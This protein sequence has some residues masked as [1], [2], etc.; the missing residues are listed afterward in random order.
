MP[1]LS[2]KE[3]VGGVENLVTSLDRFQVQIAAPAHHA[4]IG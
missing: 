3:K 2:A 4:F 1:T